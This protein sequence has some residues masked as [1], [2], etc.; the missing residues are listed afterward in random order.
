MLGIYSLDYDCRALLNRYFC[1]YVTGVFVTI[2]FLNHHP[3]NI[4]WPYHVADN[5]IIG[6]FDIWIRVI[7]IEFLYIRIS[8]FVSVLLLPHP[9]RILICA[10]PLTTIIWFSSNL[11]STIVTILI[12][13]AFKIVAMWIL[14][15][16][17][18]LGSFCAITVGHYVFQ[19]AI[20]VGEVYALCDEITN[21]IGAC[22]SP[23]I[24]YHY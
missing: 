8:C 14:L 5:L 23:A 9:K 20:S 11:S 16:F 22:G 19:T 1:H 6:Y 21:I 7:Y 18:S 15:A 2:Y 13:F 3:P 17:I 24:K 12:I 4:Y 10:L